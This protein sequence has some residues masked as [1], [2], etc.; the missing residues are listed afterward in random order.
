MTQKIRISEQGRTQAKMYSPL[1]S[2][3]ESSDKKSQKAAEK[4]REIV[5]NNKE[6]LLDLFTSSK[7]FFNLREL[8]LELT[9]FSKDK[10]DKEKAERVKN[11]DKKITDEKFTASQIKYYLL[12]MIE[13]GQIKAIESRTTK[14]ALVYYGTMNGSVFDTKTALE[15]EARVIKTMGTYKMLSQEAKEIILEDVLDV[16]TYVP[17]TP[18]DVA[19][20]VFHSPETIIGFLSETKDP[21]IIRIGRG[22]HFTYKKAPKQQIPSIE[23]KFDNQS[24]KD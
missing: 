22:T 7:R 20:N 17:M 1:D 24:P 18:T 3:F 6:L 10:R 12:G 21:R 23:K 15:L 13:L 19:K 11:R 8:V 9:K 16:L 5:K 2:P 4:S 14:G